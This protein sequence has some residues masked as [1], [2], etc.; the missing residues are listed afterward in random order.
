MLLSTLVVTPYLS[1]RDHPQFGKG[2]AYLLIGDKALAK[3]HWDL[4]FE[5]YPD[6]ALRGAFMGLLENSDLWQ[7][8][9]QFKAYLDINHR[10]SAAL[11]GIAL[12]TSGMKLSTSIDNLNRTVRLEPTY[13]SAYLCLGFEYLKQ[14]NYPL[15]RGYFNK[16]LMNLR[17]PEYKILLAK[18]DLLL[19]QPAEVITLLKQE[20]DQ[21]PDNFYFNF[22]VAEAYFHL[23]QLDAMDKYIQTA[24]EVKPDSNEAQL[25]KVKYLTS[26]GKS[27]QALGILK[28]LKYQDYDEE[29]YKTYARV[30]LKLKDRKCKNYLDDV[31]SRNHWDKEINEMMGLFYIWRNQEKAN[32]QNWI[33]R[34][35]LSGSP[36]SR[37]KSQFPAKYQFPEYSS[38]PFFHI[39]TLRWLS[40]NVLLMSAIKVSGDTEKLFLIQADDLKI[41]SILSYTG[42][43]QDIALSSD[44]KKIVFSTAAMEG[45]SIYLY[46]VEVSDSYSSSSLVFSRLLPI[47]AMEVGFNYTG[48]IAY[49]T[50]SRISQLAFES[51]FS[52][53]SEI[54]EKAPVYPSYP[55]PIYKLNFLSKSLEAIDVNDMKEV[56][57]APIESV[58]KYVVVYEGH[59][60]KS[61]VQTLIEKGRKLDLTSSEIIKIYFSKDL[62]SFIIYL[63]DLTNAFQALI[64]EYTNNRLFRIDETMFIGEGNYAEIN[65]KNF[66][67]QKK[68]ILVLT[69][70][71]QRRLINFNYQS[72]L[73]LE[74]ADKVIESYYDQNHDMFYILTERSK[75]SYFTET[76]LEIVSE[77]PFLR[78]SVGVR[79]D[80]N[81]LLFTKG[82]DQVYFTTFNGE[83]LMMDGEH[84]FYYVCPSVAGSL[85]AI[86]PTGKKTA[87]FINERLVILDSLYKPPQR[88]KKQ[89]QEK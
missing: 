66:D 7:V 86:S 3:K 74:L 33:N 79:R 18:L 20:A 11:V 36:V 47:P 54:G 27:Q 88:E 21:Q 73:T 41:L 29:Y 2:V 42:E 24:L 10:S 38:L 89:D 80:L 23:D 76:N 30:L 62:S 8:T 15:A 71:K 82:N 58:K 55:F 25:L 35:L 6:P 69:K 17:I 59:Q 51:P 31:Y 48:S 12:A 53:V 68:E 19:D 14:R 75:K 40:D 72:F 16:A 78:E 64:Y 5:S 28:T 13:S 65:L 57:K 52:L 9:K 34:A 77:E 32:V 85:H 83:T 22:L 61:S 50:D 70:D 46:G 43:L 49:I 1:S 63:S 39:K 4:F 45:R 60:S 87:A 44:G 67:P 37:L 26:K 56:A 81:Q 84:H